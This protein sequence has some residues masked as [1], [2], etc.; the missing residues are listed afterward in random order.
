MRSLG[1]NPKFSLVEG[2]EEMIRFEFDMADNEMI[3]DLTVIITYQE[4]DKIRNASK[5]CRVSLTIFSS[6]T[7]ILLMI[8]RRS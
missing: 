3:D 5:A 7:R 8:L 2:L 1:W 4:E 6:L